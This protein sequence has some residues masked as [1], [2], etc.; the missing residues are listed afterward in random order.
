ME[1]EDE[2]VKIIVKIQKLKK[3]VGRKKKGKVSENKGQFYFDN[4]ENLK[5]EKLFEIEEKLSK[6][7]VK[8][9]RKLKFKFELGI[10][11]I[12]ILYFYL[13]NNFK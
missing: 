9:G 13:D 6:L 5:L 10:G 8:R 11:F 1:E 12:G 2:L 7:K 4:E 3:I